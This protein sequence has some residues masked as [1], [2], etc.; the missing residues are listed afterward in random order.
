MQACRHANTH[1][2]A[3]TEHKACMH[4][5][6][7]LHATPINHPLHPRN[8]AR[9]S[10]PRGCTSG[11]RAWA[12]LPF[13][14]SHMPLAHRVFMEA[15][16]EDMLRSKVGDL[17]AQSTQDGFWDNAVSLPLP[18]L[19]TPVGGPTHRNAALWALMLMLSRTNTTIR[20]GISPVYGNLEQ[21]TMRGPEPKE[22]ILTWRDRRERPSRRCEILMLQR[23]AWS[24]SR[25]FEASGTTSRQ[26]C[27]CWMRGRR[28][29]T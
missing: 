18:N 22:G 20:I 17:E 27:P 28:T 9:I 2:C 11:F 19:L 7:Q 29:R 3:F 13:V 15:V 8:L 5:M 21:S 16:N 26:F 25:D 24:R 14:Y 12:D 6:H 4:R 10:R 1:I 23:R